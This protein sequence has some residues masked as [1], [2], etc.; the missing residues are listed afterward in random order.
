ML[1]LLFASIAL[2]SAQ[3]AKEPH[4]NQ[5]T[6]YKALLD[7]G[8]T[9]GSDLKA[10][11]PPPSMPDGLDGAKQKAIIT[12]LIGN[13]YTYEDFTRKSAVAPLRLRVRDINPLDPETPVRAVDIWFVAHGDTLLGWLGYAGKL[14]RRVK[15]LK[16]EDL[17]VRGIRSYDGAGEAFGHA[18]FDVLERVR[19]RSTV[20]VAWARTDESFLVAGEVDQRFRDD[21]EF[22]NQWQPI[23]RDGGARKLGPLNPW[24]GGGFYLKVTR[25]A[26]P[27]G[28][29]FVELH[30]IFAEP[31][32]WF[33]GANLLRSKFPPVVQYGVRTIRKEWDGT[34]ER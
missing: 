33:D 25:L 26:E 31:A 13:D 18:E 11:F 3:P 6:L 20:R 30:V 12:N 2:T 34:G 8:L 17:A 28:A 23:T 4:E 24:G 15:L 14:L 5:N 27:A 10:K 1:A 21:P 16:K 19:L 22:P 29:M 32:G 7:P 9:V